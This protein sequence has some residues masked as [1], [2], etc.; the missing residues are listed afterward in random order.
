M[1]DDV[2][3]VLRRKIEGLLHETGVEKGK[4]VIKGSFNAVLIK[5]DLDNYIYHTCLGIPIP[6]SS[7]PHT[8]SQSLSS[9]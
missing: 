8:T 2:I 6:L 9:R 7:T 3:K 4:E 1:E 5:L